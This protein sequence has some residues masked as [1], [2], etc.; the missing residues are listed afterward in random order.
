M[1]LKGNS[2]RNILQPVRLMDNRSEF[3][4]SKDEQ[5]FTNQQKTVYKLWENFR[6][7]FN[8]NVS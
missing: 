7:M 1:L 3:H 8:I 6:I 5:R 2:W 4:R